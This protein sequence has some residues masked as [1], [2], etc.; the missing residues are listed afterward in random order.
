MENDKWVWAD[1]EDLPL[2]LPTLDNKLMPI[3]E[4]PTAAPEPA[5]PQQPDPPPAPAVNRAAARRVGPAPAPPRPPAKKKEPPPS[6]V[7]AIVLHLEGQLDD[8]IR[9]IQAGLVAGEP[10]AELTAA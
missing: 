8:A 3:A 2:V 7:K 1:K 6:L 5:A 10:P 9:E 4:W